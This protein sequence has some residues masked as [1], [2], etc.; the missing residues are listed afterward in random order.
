[1]LQKIRPH[2]GGVQLIP[3]GVRMDRIVQS[4]GLTSDGGDRVELRGSVEALL[5]DHS[6]LDT[7]AAHGWPSGQPAPDLAARTEKRAFHMPVHA[8]CFPCMFARRAL[9]SCM[10]GRVG[11]V[12][13]DVVQLL[14]SSRSETCN[15][16]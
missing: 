7:R 14:F 4:D 15:S 6:V 8:P 11:M 9:F 2:Q 16:C 10:V 5:W 1:M 13:C 12:A 3:S